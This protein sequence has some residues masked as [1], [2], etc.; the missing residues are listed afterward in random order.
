[1]EGFAWGGVFEDMDLDGNL[2]L[3]V[4]QNYIKWPFHKFF[5]LPGRA[6]AQKDGEPAFENAPQW[7]LSNKYFGQSSLVVD[8]DGDGR[9]DFL[10]INMDGPLRAFINNSKAPFITLVLPDD[11]A[12]LGTRVH[13]VTPSGK[14]YTRQVVDAAGYLTD[15]TPEITFGAGQGVEKLVVDFP[16]GTR[17]IIPR[18]PIN[19]RIHLPPK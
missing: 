10:W 15:Q 9:Q 7:G 12:T 17:Q 11:L 4:A 2:D 1:D 18:P 13:L 16:D 6:Y 14:T 19:T 5:R 8:L 3:F